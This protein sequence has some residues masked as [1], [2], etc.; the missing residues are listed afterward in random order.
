MSWVYVVVNCQKGWLPQPFVGLTTSIKWEQQKTNEYV[1]DSEQ[2]WANWERLFLMDDFFKWNFFKYQFYRGLRFHLMATNENVM[3]CFQGLEGELYNYKCVCWKLI[4]TSMLSCCH[5]VSLLKVLTFQVDFLVPCYNK[6]KS[7]STSVWMQQTILWFI[8]NVKSLVT[9]Y[10]GVHI[11][12]VGN[13][14]LRVFTYVSY[15]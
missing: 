5:I 15:D 10:S 6:K 8:S 12:I 7:G 2:F 13:W 11:T 14:N 9:G 4:I 3:R 1:D